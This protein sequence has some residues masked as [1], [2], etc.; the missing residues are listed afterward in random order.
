[1]IA[2]DRNQLASQARADNPV[3]ESEPLTGPPVAIDQLAQNIECCYAR[4]G[5]T[6]APAVRVKIDCAAHLNPARTF[7]LPTKGGRMFCLGG[8]QKLACDFFAGFARRSFLLR[9]FLAGRLID[10]LHGKP[11][12]AAVIKAQ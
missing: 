11:H 9:D 10:D 12:L 5:V 3:R 1:V 2:H 6:N 7:D 8:E 4:A